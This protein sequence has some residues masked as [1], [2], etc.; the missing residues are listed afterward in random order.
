[1]EPDTM[2]FNQAQ[3]GALHIHVTP[4]NDS[5]AG[6]QNRNCYPVYKRNVL[7]QRKMPN[8]TD[9]QAGKTMQPLPDVS[10]ELCV[11]FPSC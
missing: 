11:F 8:M 2:T 4:S 6:P 3:D 9:T 7:P 1:M 10:K 5:L